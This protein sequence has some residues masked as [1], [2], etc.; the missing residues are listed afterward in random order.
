MRAACSQYAV[1]L[2]S[3]CSAIF[4]DGSPSHIHAH[5]SV[6]APAEAEA[7]AQ[8]LHAEEG[9]QDAGPLLYQDVDIPN[10][11]SE[12]EEESDD[13]PEQQP[14]PAAAVNGAASGA[15]GTAATGDAPSTSAAAATAGL[16][17]AQL[18]AVCGSTAARYRCPGCD[19]RSCSLACSKAHKESSGCSGK[20]DRLKFVSLQ[21]FDDRTLLSGRL[22]KNLTLQDSTDAASEGACLAPYLLLCNGKL[23]CL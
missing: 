9:E 18:C 3:P 14:K 22:V 8:G 7:V 2:Y 15:P 17:C 20:R 4:P 12:G 5:F 16:G 1:L 21:E 19:V 13:L 6:S 11:F 23:A 10:D